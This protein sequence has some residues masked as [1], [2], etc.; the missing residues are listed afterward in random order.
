VIR[1]GL[2]DQFNVLVLASLMPG[3]GKTIRLASTV[4]VIQPSPR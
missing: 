1:I 4:T 2:V 3:K